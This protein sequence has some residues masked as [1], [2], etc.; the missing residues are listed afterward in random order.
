VLFLF[1]LAAQLTNVDKDVSEV[2]L[3]QVIEDFGVVNSLYVNCH[4]FL[5]PLSIFVRTT[6]W[7]KVKLMMA[8]V[9]SLELSSVDSSLEASALGATCAGFFIQVLM[10]KVGDLTPTEPVTNHH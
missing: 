6:T 2:F 8:D 4:H 10:T 9:H 3:Y 7:R 5:T 1:S